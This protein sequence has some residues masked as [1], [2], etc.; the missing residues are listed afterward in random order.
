MNFPA[1]HA[2]IW[3][4]KLIVILILGS[5]LSFHSYNP[6]LD[7]Y[8]STK[9]ASAMAAEPTRATGNK[10]CPIKRHRDAANLL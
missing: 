8:S 2:Q 5:M 7:L 4:T 10:I 1:W 3:P 6:T 9:G